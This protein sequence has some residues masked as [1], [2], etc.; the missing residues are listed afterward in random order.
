MAST[1]EYP[2]GATPLDPD[3]MQGLKFAHVTTRGELD[4]LEQANIQSGLLWLSKTPRGDI[5]DDHFLRQLHTKLFGDVWAWAGSYRL[6]EKNIGIDPRHISVQLKLL[7]DDVRFWV[8]HQ[9]YA[10]HE[11]AIRFHH[12]LVYIHP[13]P[14]GNGRHARIAADVLL[15]QYFKLPPINW[16]GGYDLQAINQRRREYINGLRA[17]DHSDYQPLLGLLK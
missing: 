4:Q 14:N 7:L 15:E 10:P 11:T 13:F 16:A 12:K 17:A 2:D 9:T 3:E 8:Q 6:T 5:L 1:F